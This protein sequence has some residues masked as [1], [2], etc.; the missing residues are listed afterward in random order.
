MAICKDL[1]PH[2]QY[3]TY[4]SSTSAGCIEPAVSIF[5]AR[6]RLNPGTHSPRRPSILLSSAIR[7]QCCRVRR[8]RL[9]GCPLLQPCTSSSML[10]T[11]LHTISCV[12]AGLFLQG[13]AHQSAARILCPRYSQ[14]G[15]MHG[16]TG[17]YA[18]KGLTGLSMYGQTSTHDLSFAG[19]Q[20][21]LLWM[22]VLK[23]VC[24][25][26]N[27]LQG[28]FCSHTSGLILLLSLTVLPTCSIM[29]QIEAS[30]HSIVL[31][32]CSGGCLL[33]I[34]LRDQA[35]KY[36]PLISPCMACLP[37]QRSKAH[38]GRACAM[39]QGG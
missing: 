9:S 25:E 14:A 5:C 31:A 26:R 15:L 13:S 30:R 4:L 36:A 12:R 27:C 21:M 33:D 8:Q 1:S 24:V 29:C 16:L 19:L 17:L 2:L 20:Q 32:D 23:H 34:L 38:K 18:A 22:K 35:H 6:C 7:M 11:T 3:H 39:Y 10:C 37:S 28:I